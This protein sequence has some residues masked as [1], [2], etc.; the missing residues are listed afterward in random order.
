MSSIDIEAFQR[1]VPSSVILRDVPVKRMMSLELN[2][3]DNTALFHILERVQLSDAHNDAIIEQLSTS[4]HIEWGMKSLD[5]V[6]L[7]CVVSVPNSTLMM[8]PKGS[9]DW[10]SWDIATVE[11]QVCSVENIPKHHINASC[12]VDIV[13]LGM[14]YS[15]GIGNCE[16]EGW[17]YSGAIARF[18]S[19]LNFTSTEYECSQ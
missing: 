17:Y 8:I 15:N 10:D 14:T 1:V 16:H 3:S 9:E 12:Q 18:S 19:D 6:L 13:I 5:S 4:G 7:D 2:R 11:D